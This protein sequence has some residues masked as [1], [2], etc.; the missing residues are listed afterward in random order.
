MTYQYDY[1]MLSCTADIAV[2]NTQTNTIL[3]IQRLNGQWA[4]P[5]GFLNAD[6]ETA[7][8]AAKRELQEETGLT[9][10]GFVYKLNYRDSVDR[11]ERKRVI[12]FPF[13]VA[14]NDAEVVEVGDDAISY[15][16]VSFDEVSQ[17]KLAFD[18]NDI[19]EEV[20]AKKFLLI[21]KEENV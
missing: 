9:M 13:M 11:D 6:T 14:Y 12:T 19:V 5:G 18:H 7:I 2:I 10:Y 16:W 3:L 20:R 8:D 17:M 4:L 15:K 1:P 21:G